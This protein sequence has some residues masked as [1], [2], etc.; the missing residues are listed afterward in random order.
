M[1]KLGFAKD[2]KEELTQ[3][4]VDECCKNAELHAMLRLNSSIVLSNG[5]K[6]IEFTTM[7]PRI[8]RRFFS[9]IKVLYGSNMEILVK[10]QTN[11]NKKHVYLVEVKDKI[12]EI[13]NEH[14]LLESIVEDSLLVVKDCCKASYL[15]GVFMCCG[16]ITEPTHSYHLE[17]SCGNSN[18]I[19]F[20]QKVM[21]DYDLNAK[22]SRRRNMLLIYIKNAEK[23]SDFLRIIGSYNSLMLFEDVRIR[24]DYN[25]MVNR[26]S[27][28][29]MFNDIKTIDAAN[30][31]L[32]HIKYI[33]Q[34]VNAEKIPEKLKE[35]MV[36]RKKYPQ[37]NLQTL[38]DNALEMG[39]KISKSCI[40]HRMRKIK[41]WYLELIEKNK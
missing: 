25:T 5:K 41:D 28:C 13:I 20:L 36:L 6:Y 2:L 34:N 1:I 3:I 21:N 4:E 29:Q 24:K 35:V 37:D 15:R 22:I 31:Q 18:E 17:I 16:S 14:Q 11:L 8:A 9:N 12:D 40:N 39:I 23:I 32:K 26:I 10:Q 19:Y 33:E 7:N 27:I 30:E 38:S